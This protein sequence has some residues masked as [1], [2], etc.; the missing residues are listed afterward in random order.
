MGITGQWVG[1]F[2]VGISLSLG[3]PRVSRLS[4]SVCVG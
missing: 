4:T 2:L 3:P 1:I